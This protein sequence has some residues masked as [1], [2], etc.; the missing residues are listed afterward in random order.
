MNDRPA[1]IGGL[2]ETG[3]R[4]RSVK[5]ELRANL[6]TVLAEKRPL[7]PGIVGYDATVNAILAS[8]RGRSS[9]PL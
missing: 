1:T 3:Y 2:R 4:P 7:F 8:L 9:L 5:Q 6:I